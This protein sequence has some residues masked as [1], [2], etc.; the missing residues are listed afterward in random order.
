MGQYIAA[1]A[2]G[3]SAAA[4]IVDHR[5]SL[6]NFVDEPPEHRPDMGASDLVPRLN[7]GRRKHQRTHDSAVT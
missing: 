4:K 5:A 3:W 1:K 7:S 2:A 6:G